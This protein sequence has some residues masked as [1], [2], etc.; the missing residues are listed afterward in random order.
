MKL[1][2]KSFDQILKER[3]LE[4]GG[5]VQRV[6]DSEVVRLMTP[7]T[8]KDS[9]ALIDSI[10]QSD[11]GTGLIHQG[12]SSAPYARRWYYT[13]AN[14]QGAPRRGTYW[15]ER[16]KNNGGKKSILQSAIREAGAKKG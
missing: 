6:I 3:G 16:M 9:G 15:F 12:G 11:I 4:P 13:S 10:P 7:Y 14:F 8:P 5:R 1:K 2:M